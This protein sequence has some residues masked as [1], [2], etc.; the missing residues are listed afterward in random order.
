MLVSKIYEED[1]TFLNVEDA[2]KYMKET[3]FEKDVTVYDTDTQKAYKKVRQLYKVIKE[4]NKGKALNLQCL[5]GNPFSYRG[6][7]G[8]LGVQCYSISLGKYEHNKD[9]IALFT[10]WNKDV[11]DMSAEYC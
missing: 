10:G 7:V 2:V 3:D 4:Y 1:P 9:L 6:I 8:C 5:P 11:L